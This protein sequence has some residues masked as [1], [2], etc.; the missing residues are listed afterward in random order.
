MA[1]AL[2]Q[3]PVVLDSFQL[4]AIAAK[5]PTWRN[6]LIRRIE[7]HEFDAIFLIRRPEYVG[8]S[9]STRFWYRNLHFGPQISAAIIR[10]YRVDRQVAG[11]WL[12]RPRH[13]TVGTVPSALRG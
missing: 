3:R 5:H 9:A 13:G 2:G 6:D 7:S 1:Y 10:S 12:Y 8:R 11:L 4:Q